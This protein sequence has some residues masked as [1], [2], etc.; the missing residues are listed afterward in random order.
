M[1]EIEGQAMK[2]VQIGQ[3]T[4]TWAMLFR[5]DEC[6][7]TMSTSIE[8]VDLYFWLNNTYKEIWRHLTRF[9]NHSPCDGEDFKTIFQFVDS[10]GNYKTILVETKQ[11]TSEGYN[12]RIKEKYDWDE[13]DYEYIFISSNC[14]KI[15]KRD[16][17][18]K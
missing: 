15:L 5:Y 6:P 7:L 14:K 10:T 8:S 16:S 2:K 1:H 18:K 9:E 12:L 17:M 3:G 11:E 4:T 13:S